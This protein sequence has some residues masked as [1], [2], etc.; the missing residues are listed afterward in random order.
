MRALFKSMFEVLYPEV[1]R[2]KRTNDIVKRV[3]VITPDRILIEN[4]PIKRP[5]T[6]FNPAIILEDDEVTFYTR[7]VLGYFTY[8]SAVA[9]FS[10]SLDE[11]DALK[12]YRA[13]ITVYPSMRYDFWGVEDPRV[14]T[15]DGRLLMTYCGRTISYFNPAVRIERTLPV[16]AVREGEW[17]KRLVFRM[18]EEMRKKV[19]SD[20]DGFLFKDRKLLLFHR[21]HIGERFYLTRSEVEVSLP[22]QEFE[23]VEAESTK[24]VMEP[25]EFEQ[26]LGWGTP[27]VSVGREYVL[28]LHAVD[29]NRCVY[30]VFACLIDREG[31]LKA[32]TPEYIMEPKE[33][34]EIYG[35]RPYT[36]F[37]C[38]AQKLDDAILISY[39]GGDSVIGIGKVDI[40]ELMHI[41]DKG[42]LE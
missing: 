36:V 5:I 42:S 7:I 3:G 11:L 33:S 10:M 26:K 38:G 2:E 19:V 29:S 8:A 18:P 6:A 25:A 13:R 20:K 27:P 17:V 21:L 4:H 28:F 23:V 30:R 1:K 24:V 32:V 39:G 31:N 35:D 40:S 16:T 15:L 9:E 41:L 34:Y 22:L 14:Y 12:E 37:P